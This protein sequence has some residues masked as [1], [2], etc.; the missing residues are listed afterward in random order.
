VSISKEKTIKKWSW[1]FHLVKPLGFWLHWRAYPLMANQ[2][3]YFHLK[4]NA[5]DI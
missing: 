3:S 4:A 2:L 1:S 5:R